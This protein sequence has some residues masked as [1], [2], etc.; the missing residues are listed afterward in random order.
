MMIRQI[1]KIYY[2]RSKL[3]SVINDV[4]IDDE[5]CDGFLFSLIKFNKFDN[6]KNNVNII[7]L[8]ADII[9]D[10]KITFVKL[11]LD[12]YSESYYK[13]YKS[14]IT[15]EKSIINKTLLNRWIK[16]FNKNNILGFNKY[17]FSNNVVVIKKF[18]N[19]NNSNFYYSIMIYLNGQ[20]DIIIDNHD[21][22]NLTLESLLNISDDYNLI[23]KKLRSYF[24]V[25]PK[26]N[27]DVFKN[28][29][30][31]T[32]VEY[33]NYIINYK[34][35]NFVAINNRFLKNISNFLKI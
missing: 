33:M 26:F 21:S 30:S 13:I 11:V 17:I 16:D 27:R 35:K 3:M 23:I 9:L 6:K 24:I 15:S 34:M 19:I 10:D 14:S 28:N 8:F 22:V 7:K 29:N 4:S 25:S 20:V 5:T 2:N 1:L 31:N 32:M 12:D 18:L